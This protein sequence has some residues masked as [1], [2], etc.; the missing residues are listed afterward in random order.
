MGT[1]DISRVP[2]EIDR[3]KERNDKMN[4]GQ[5]KICGQNVILE[6]IYPEYEDIIA[7]EPNDSRAYYEACSEMATM[8][9]NCKEGELEREK[10]KNKEEAV[11]SINDIFSKNEDIRD[12]LSL[13]ITPLQEGNIDSITIKSNN[14]KAILNM[15]S[16]GYIRIKR[17]ITDTVSDEI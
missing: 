5:C 1:R 14:M 12:I 15:N 10:K 4:I 17:E 6:D 7:N 8:Q 3:F 13:C 2:R 11:E 16:K 9:C